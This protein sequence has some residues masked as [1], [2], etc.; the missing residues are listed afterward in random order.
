[1]A[2]TFLPSMVTCLHLP[3]VIVRTGCIVVIINHMDFH[4]QHSPVRH[5]LIGKE[6]HIAASHIIV[7][8]KRQPTAVAENTI[9]VIT[10]N[11]K[12]ILVRM[13]LLLLNLDQHVKYILLN[14]RDLFGQSTWSSVSLWN[15]HL[16]P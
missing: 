15:L 8:R 6:L 7:I 3:F 11:L 12:L 16:L 5:N 14:F 9:I 13:D 2:F 10:H 4:K 1:M